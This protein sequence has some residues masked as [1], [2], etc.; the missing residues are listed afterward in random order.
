MAVV[1]VM[2]GIVL[3]T[4]G[5]LFGKKYSAEEVKE[6]WVSYTTI[7]EKGPVEAEYN[8]D[9]W[10][11]EYAGNFSY[12]DEEQTAYIEQLKTSYNDFMAVI[13]ASPVK[14]EGDTK[15]ALDTNTILFNAATQFLRANIIVKTAYVTYGSDGYD[16]AIAKIDIEYPDVSSNELAKQ[17]YD[18]TR[19]YLKT[20]LDIYK[21]EQENLCIDKETNPS[22]ACIEALSRNIAQADQLESDFDEAVT[23]MYTSYNSLIIG[24]KS[25]VNTLNEAL[26]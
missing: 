2:V 17:L 10:W 12:L 6:K 22:T 26:L 13:K 20:A 24:L 1:L 21:T 4:T 11:I 25:C 8:W 3:M 23:G 14:L 15:E 18:S 5:G 16:A 7:L 19:I 9:S